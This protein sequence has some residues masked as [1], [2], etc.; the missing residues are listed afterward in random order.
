MRACGTELRKSLVCS[1]RGSTRSSAYFSSPM[2]F[3]L[4]STLMRGFPMTFNRRV[5]PLF[6][7]IQRLPGG[8]RLL[9]ANTS[10]RQ[11]HRFE[12]FDVAR[13]AAD[14]PRESL[15]DFVA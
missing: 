12:Y 11:F 13:A 10:G 3:A 14:V 2:H 6:P 8:L 15:F 7:A 9:T 4:A 5:P 1:I